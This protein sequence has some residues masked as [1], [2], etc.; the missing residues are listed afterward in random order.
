MKLNSETLPSPPENK[1][2]RLISFQLYYIPLLI[3]IM[4]LFV[5]GYLGSR[6]AFE[7]LNRHAEL[8]AGSEEMRLQAQQMQ[9]LTDLMIHETDEEARLKIRS[10]LILAVAELEHCYNDDVLALTDFNATDPY[11][12]ELEALFFGEPKRLSERM[13]AVF[14]DTEALLAIDDRPI[15]RLDPEW[16]NLR[17]SLSS[18][19]PLIEE[20]SQIYAANSDIFIQQIAALAMGMLVLAVT[21]VVAQVW[22]LYRPL[23]QKL[24]AV[25]LERSDREQQLA[26]SKHFIEQMASTSPALLYVY[27]RTT[28]QSVYSNRTLFNAG[29]QDMSGKFVYGAMHPEDL[30]KVPTWE[31]KIE[32]L[33]D[34]EILK[35]EY[36]L[37]DSEGK[38]RWLDVRETPFTRDAHGRPKQ[39]MGSS[40]DITERMQAE[41][42]LS[43]ERDFNESIIN[44]TSALIFVTDPE[45]R[46]VR[47]NRACE[48]LTG[49][50]AKDI[51]GKLFWELLVPLE[52][53]E[54]AWSM[55]HNPSSWYPA[56]QEFHWLT[57]GGNRAL[58]RWSTTP[59]VMHG[60]VQ[61]RI[62]SGIDITEQRHLETANLQLNVEQEKAKFLRAFVNDLSHDIRTPLSVLNT[63]LYLIRRAKT[64]DQRGERVSIMEEQVSR[65]NKLIEQLVTLS[66]LE[67]HLA[68]MVEAVSV[69][70][71]LR[72]VRTAFAERSEK[73]QVVIEID[74]DNTVPSFTAD[75]AQLDLALTNLVENA[76]QHT[77]PAGVITLRSRRSSHD[78]VIEIEDTGVGIPQAEQDA[79]FE[80]FYRI[81]KA[82]ATDTGGMGLG[83]PIV[84]KVA[85]LH[86]GRVEL[87]ST[88]GVGSLFR[89]ILPLDTFDA[90][91]ITHPQAPRNS[92]Q[93]SAKS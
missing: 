74:L 5:V 45:G 35:I 37:K 52:D 17:I 63:S 61:Y 18:I 28:R 69:N 46:I 76:L 50:M 56:T 3:V 54:Q 26:E 55:L 32:A 42:E 33:K 15:T 91:D 30:A 8:V 85:E 62:T 49:Y 75:Q 14:D 1:P 81:D 70:E 16:V 13:Q 39:M 29:P 88:Q 4:L 7:T 47:F 84:Q 77:P 93:S 90:R 78:V 67:H 73:K 89:L 80:R 21:A 66:R 53:V 19:L 2:Q 58:V 43:T 87:E 72:H 65:V 9:L 86:Q 71:L 11:T 82:R 83:L 64:D 40:I 20:A 6:W 27:D 41:T 79:I 25:V 60:S 24:E 36:R 48:K 68:S 92:V 22:M 31:S 44:T 59:L 10:G 38:W 57:R 12:T 51:V 23:R 34:G